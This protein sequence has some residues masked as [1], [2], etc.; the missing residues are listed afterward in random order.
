MSGGGEHARDLVA[1]ERNLLA[2]AVNS[3]DQP[4]A[5]ERW[6]HCVGDIRHIGLAPAR[7]FWRQRVGAE[8]CRADCDIALFG[9]PAGD[10]ERFALGVKLKSIAGF[11]FDRAYA[12]G[13]ESVQ[14]PERRGHE[15]VFAGGAG[16]ADSGKNAAAFA[17]DLFISCAGESQLEFVRPIAAVYQMGVA[18]DQR[19]RDPA[20][21][22]IDEPLSGA[23]RGWKLILRP[24]EDYPSFARGDRA[25]FDDSYARA[26]FDEG[27]KAGV[28]PNRVETVVV[29]C[30]NH[31]GQR[32]RPNR[33]KGKRPACEADREKRRSRVSSSRRKGANPRRLE[34]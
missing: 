3:V 9:E 32:H 17:G 16:R 21:F 31:G 25:G 18:I 13:D 7:E 20:P 27:C 6:D 22:A 15:L 8:E 28:E 23:R 14:S 11:D 26:P 2:K 30:L 4:F 24:G 5:R 12:L 10:G 34:V 1:G 33:P 19:G 29:V